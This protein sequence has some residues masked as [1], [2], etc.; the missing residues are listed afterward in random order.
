M[1]SVPAR[2]E[3]SGER[4]KPKP[5]GKTSRVP[6][7]K[8]ASPLLARFLSSAKISSCL[9]RRLALSISLVT[10]ISTSSV[11]WRFFR[12]DKC[13]EV[14]SEGTARNRNYG[15]L[16]TRKELALNRHAAKWVGLPDSLFLDYRVQILL[17]INAINWDFERA[18]T[19]VAS[20]LPFLNSMSVGMPRMPY[21][22]G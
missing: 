21:F 4:R 2:Y 1:S 19:L 8:I 18:P 11:T 9:R 17:S 16:E 14:D 13:I 3:V 22:G 6:S 20:R 7:P 12:S 5:S 10:A 15:K